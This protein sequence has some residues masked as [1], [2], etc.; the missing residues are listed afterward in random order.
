MTTLRDVA[1]RAGVTAQTV[2]NVVN[3]RDKPPY[4]TAATRERVLRA[5]T[6]LDYHPNGQARSLRNRRA[7][8]LGFVIVDESPAF[9]SDLFHSEV[10][11]GIA[12]I[13]RASDRW[14]LIH[15]LL[16]DEKAPGHLLQ[17]YLQRRI[18]GAVVTLSG[19]R[20]VRDACIQRLLAHPCP[21]VLFEE[22]IDCPH[23][24]SMMGDNAG[25]ASQAVAHL[26][27]KGHER[28]VFL[29]GPSAWPAVEQRVGGYTAAMREAGL[30]PRVFTGRDGDAVANA[31]WSLRTG[32]RLGAAVLEAHPDLTALIAANDVLAAGAMQAVKAVGRQVPGD[33]AIIGFDD[34]EFAQYLDPPLTSVK[35]AGLEMGR[36]AAQMLLQYGVS[37]RFEDKE[38]MFPT[39][40]VRRASA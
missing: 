23:G 31:E 16:P 17:P 18:D 27:R 2:S 21:F 7:L 3:G 10:A 12:E 19:P 22:R 38:V 20:A 36:M 33:V 15:G 30:E 25:G 29:A 4:V 40:L 14:L 32:Q 6:E 39:T 9:L 37:G 13:V 11:S 26:R 8:T 1:E 5:L 35:L 24:V 28:I 34:F